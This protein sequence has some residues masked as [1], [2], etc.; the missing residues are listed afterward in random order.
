MHQPSAAGG[1]V[2]PGGVPLSQVKVGPSRLIDRIDE[3][4]PIVKQHGPLET[5]VIEPPRI[6]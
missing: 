3:Q 2:S 5:N 4:Q 6:G 1:R